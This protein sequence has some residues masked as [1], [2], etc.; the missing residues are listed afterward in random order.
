MR[1]IPSTVLQCIASKKVLRLIIL[2]GP[3][4]AAAMPQ[5]SVAVKTTLPCTACHTL[6]NWYTLQLSGFSH[7]Q[8]AFPLEGRHQSLSCRQCHRGADLAAVHRFAETPTSCSSCH[9][10]PHFQ[11]FDQSCEACHTPR[12][13]QVAEIQDRHNETRFPLTGAH[14]NL[15]CD[16]CHQSANRNQFTSLPLDCNGCHQSQYLATANPPH[17]RDHYPHDC[18]LCHNSRSWQLTDF[19]HNRLG[20]PLV[21]VHAQLRCDRCHSDQKFA[22]Q[23]GRCYDCHA[24]DLVTKAD[25]SH[26]AAGFGNDCEQ[27]HSVFNWRQTNF[28]HQIRSGY[29]LTGAHSTAPCGGCHTDNRFEDIATD[30]YVCHQTNYE[31]AT[32]PEHKQA[33][34]PQDCSQCHSTADWRTTTIDHNLTAFPLRG[35]HRSVACVACHTTELGFSNLPLTCNGCHDYSQASSWDHQVRD[36]PQ[37]CDRCHSEFG[38]T[39]ITWNHEGVTSGCS[40]CHTYDYTQTQDPNHVASNFG[41]SCEVCHSVGAW[42]PAAYNHDLTGFPLTGA[43]QSLSCESCHVDNQFTGIS[44]DCA[45]SGCHLTTYNQTT[46]PNHTLKGYPPEDCALCHN[47]VSFSP[48]IFQHGSTQEV[49]ATC[50]MDEYNNTQAPD[51]AANGYSTNCEVCHG[52]AAWTPSTVDHDQTGFPL[53]GRHASVDCASCHVNNVFAGTPTDC[54]ASGCHLSVWANTTDPNHEDRGWSADLCEQCHSPVGWTPSIWSHEGVTQGCENCHAQDVPSAASS[55]PDH[56][57]FPPNCEMCHNA[58]AWLPSHFDHSDQLTG[59]ALIGQ[60]YDPEG[61]NCSQCHVNNQWT[62]IPNTCEAS[63]CHA[64]NYSN[65][66]NPD[67]STR[68]WPADQCEDCHTPEGWTPSIWVHAG[69]TSGCG[70]CH[71]ADF[72]ATT[73][74]PHVSNNFPQTCETCH[75]VSAWTPAEFD[76]SAAQTGFALTGA[77]TSLDCSTCHA[78]G[79]DPPAQPRT[80]AAVDCHLNDY[81]NTDNPNHAAAGFP[82]DCTACHSTSTWE[83][84]TFDHDALYFPIYSGKH[85]NRWNTCSQCHTNTGNYAEF[86]CFGSGCHGVTEMN[87]EHCEG[88]SCKSCNGFTYP[89]TGVTSQDCYTCHPTGSKNDCEGGGDDDEG[90]DRFNP[91]KPR[92]PQPFPGR[93]F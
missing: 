64:E 68:V 31:Q 48:S 45:S 53:V 18:T 24:Q 26:Q 4:V 14:A 1:L 2:F 55:A 77:H 35:R 76:H 47:T 34:F 58:G 79:Y 56:S 15:T 10:D 72:N 43:H 62:G 82:L 27:C 5:D 57:Q 40:E 49:C 46:S 92:N 69:V 37:N 39:P 71:Q 28:N 38:W 87:N 80:C 73:D 66:Q 89:A 11:Q 75:N 78:D 65:T 59:F 42:S 19:D 32:N 50:H 52:T 7:E 30:C 54:A 13:W 86:T 84:A 16:A 29:E 20:F 25:F 44:A 85:A 3:L 93:P 90:G 61:Q 67:H 17:E 23:S 63:G 36:Y 21:G 60:H 83:G 41:T 9:Q 12:T 8:T 74:P 6:S 70:P 91:G 81:N 22:T 51:H 88:G 33:G